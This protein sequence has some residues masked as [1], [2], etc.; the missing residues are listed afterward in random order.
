[1]FTVGDQTQAHTSTEGP[2]Q[3]PTNVPNWAERQSSKHNLSIFC[4]A[5]TLLLKLLQNENEVLAGE[6]LNRVQKQKHTKATLYSTG[7]YSHYLETT[8]FLLFSCSVVSNSLQLHG[9]KH[10]KVPCPSASPRICS[11]SCPLSQ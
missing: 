3:N 4:L 6:V 9:L 11:N 1:M 5:P 2:S 7:N 8:Y 10:A